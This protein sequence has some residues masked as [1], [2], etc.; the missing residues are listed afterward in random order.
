MYQ[1]FVHAPVIAKLCALAIL[2]LF[3]YF[4]CWFIPRAVLR[5]IALKRIIAGLV[6]L[7]AG[8]D[9]APLF[10]KHKDLAHLWSEYDETLFKQE[11]FDSEQRDYVFDRKRST[12]PAEMFFNTQ[13]TVDSYVG[14]EFFKHVPGILTG[15]GIIGT[16]FG[17]LHGLDAFNVSADAAQVRDSLKGLLGSVSEAFAVSAGA[18]A[19]A[20]IITLLEK[21]LLASLYKKSEELAIEIDKLYKA[22]AGEETLVESSNEGGDAIIVSGALIDSSSGL[23]VPVAHGNQEPLNGLSN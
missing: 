23:D 11:R 8:A 6:Q 17:I 20:M 12:V 15:I 22:G 2:V 10:E 1:T 4:V 21:W 3:A 19:C 13:S 5:G 7:E 18:I 16:F 14:A 9:P